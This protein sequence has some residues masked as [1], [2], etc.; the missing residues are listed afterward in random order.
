MEYSIDQK[1]AIDEVK[2]DYFVSIG[3]GE[4]FCNIWKTSEKESD[5]K[6]SAPLKMLELTHKKECLAVQM[7]QI[8]GQFYFVTVT[9]T[10]NVSGY[11]CNLKIK[12]KDKKCDFKVT[13]ASNIAK[14]NLFVIATTIISESEI[15]ILKGNAMNISSHQYTYLDDEG[16]SPG[17]AILIV[18]EKA[19]LTNGVDK[20]G[21]VQM[22]GLDNEQIHQKST[23][24][25]LFIGTDLDQLEGKIH[26][27]FNKKKPAGIKTGS[28]VAV[29]EQSLHAND[30]ETIN[31]VLG[32]LD[33][34]VITE[35][36]KKVSKEALQQ[37]LQNIL[38]KLQQGVQKSALLWLSSVLKL[39]WMEVIKYMNTSTIHSQQSLGTIHS[40]LNRK[41]KNLSKYYE[42]RAKLQMVIESGESL[43]Q[44]KNDEDEGKCK[45]CHFGF[46]NEGN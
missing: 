8:A 10:H 7:K 40:Y 25:G 16:K 23:A 38:I 11:I 33:L 18:E 34:H 6:I 32:N 20:S 15:L 46:R 39:R 28:L 43:M 3:S 36:V 19:Q 2:K 44:A 21:D 35:T 26:D 13:L 14:K 42:V 31:W 1:K 24:N 29:L 30:I 9:S 4:Q 22:H 17:T 37:L 5:K 41:T 12:Q 45:F 27:L